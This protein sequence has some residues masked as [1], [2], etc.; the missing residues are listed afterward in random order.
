M[1]ASD[2]RQ[3]VERFGRWQVRLVSYAIGSRF[4]CIADNV[5]PGA[6]L[7][8]VQADT[9]EEAEARALA[10]AQAKLAATRVVE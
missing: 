5:D 8:R 9:R 4:T 3:R 6:R 2:Q 1:R 10:E 7:A